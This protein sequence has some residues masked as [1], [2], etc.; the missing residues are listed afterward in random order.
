LSKLNEIFFIARPVET[1]RGSTSKG[2][3]NIYDRD[4]DEDSDNYNPPLREE[5]ENRDH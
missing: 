3:G 2:K 4:E 1:V 5:D